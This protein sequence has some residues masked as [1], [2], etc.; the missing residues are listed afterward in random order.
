M[1][2]RKRNGF[3]YDFEV[4]KIKTS[5]LNSA[6]NA[7]ISLTDSNIKSLINEI[8]Y[9]INNIHKNNPSRVTSSYELKGIVYCALVNEGFKD[10]ATS[11]M[12]TN[13]RKYS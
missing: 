8:L 6:S 13:F 10:I 1:K 2:V 5:I 9:I 11:Y 12:D 7:N 4:N 3:I